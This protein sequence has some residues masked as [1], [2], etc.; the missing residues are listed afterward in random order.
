MYCFKIKIYFYATRTKLINDV[1]VILHL[2]PGN[3]CYDMLV[4]MCNFFTDKHIGWKLSISVIYIFPCIIC[5]NNCIFHE[6]IEQPS[7]FKLQL[8]QL[9]RRI[10]LLFINFC[11][12]IIIIFRC[13]WM[14]VRRRL[15]I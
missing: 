8:A 1:D 3:V 6:Y 15:F 2:E 9:I 10:H 11:Q 14:S 4:N 5:K 12:Y 7:Y 13:I